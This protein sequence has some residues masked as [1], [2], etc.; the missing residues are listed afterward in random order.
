MTTWPIERLAGDA[1]ALHERDALA[2]TGRKVAVLAVDRDTMV[3]G[4]TQRDEIV[5]A[6]AASRMGVDV[7]RRRTGGGAVFLSPRDH[8]WIDVVLPAGDPLWHDDVAKAF[9]WLGK[10]WVHALRDIGVDGV[11]ANE[12]AVCHSILG[13]LICFAGL[14]FGEVSGADGKIVGISQR[15]TRDGA[16]FQCA[17]M[18]RWDAEAYLRLLMPGL[19]A[20]TNDDAERELAAIRV[21]PVDVEP[22]ALVDAFIRNLPT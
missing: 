21:Q 18:R 9:S 6:D 11:V 16:W 2:E 22:S 14:G 1:R 4:S 10:V 5:D 17:V 13:R 15:R 19:A 3:L 8:L 12:T 7:A 20:T